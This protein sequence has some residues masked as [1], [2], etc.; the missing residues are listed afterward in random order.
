MWFLPCSPVS[1]AALSLVLQLETGALGLPALL[2]A[3]CDRVCPG[4]RWQG[5]ERKKR[6]VDSSPPHVPF[7]PQFSGSE[8]VPLSFKCFPGFHCYCF[9]WV[10]TSYEACPGTRLY[11]EKK[12]TK[13]GFLSWRVLPPYSS[14][15]EDKAALGG[16]SFHVHC[17]A[18]EF[19]PP[20][21]P[22]Q[23]ISGQKA[24]RRIVIRFLYPQFWF[25]LPVYLLPLLF[26]SPQRATFCFPSWVV[27]C[28]WGK[29]RLYLL[30]LGTGTL[31]N[32]VFKNKGSFVE[33]G[34]YS[35][36][37]TRSSSQHFGTVA[38]FLL[39]K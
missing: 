2:H 33:K 39:S 30:S 28:I 7:K 37:T 26:E 13:K 18:P 5:E 15:Q 29:D 16:L 6:Q 22:G 10:S 4:A 36:S 34:K 9:H 12:R 20:R 23:Q 8:E 14:D 21:R 27:S 1:K 3:S 24:N 25:P 31:R 35:T 17:T 38:S 32:G 11:K 19:T